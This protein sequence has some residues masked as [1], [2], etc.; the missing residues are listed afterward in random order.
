[1]AY[2]QYCIVSIVSTTYGVWSVLYSEY[3]EYSVGVWSILYSEYS[4]YSV[5]RM[6]SVPGR[7]T[8]GAEF[9]LNG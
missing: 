8:R 7:D 3:S 5:W 1:M 4:E 9:A 6:V 2:G